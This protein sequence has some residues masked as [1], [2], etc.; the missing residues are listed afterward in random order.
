[1][2]ATSRLCKL[3]RSM[4]IPVQRKETM[5]KNN[6]EWLSKNLAKRN[7][8]HPKFDIV[9]NEISERLQTKTYYN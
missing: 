8:N 9:M 1:M 5:N 7:S 6:L 3:L 4:D 2:M